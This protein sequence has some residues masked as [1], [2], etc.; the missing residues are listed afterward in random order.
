M[1]L[2]FRRML[3]VALGAALLMGL[4]AAPLSAAKPTKKIYTLDVTPPE[5]ANGSSAVTFTATFTNTSPDGISS[6]N[7]LTLTGSSDFDFTDATVEVIPDPDGSPSGFD[8][9]VETTPQ[10]KVS[11]TGLSPVVPMHTVSIVI[12]GVGVDIPPSANCGAQ[13]IP[14]GA[15]VWTGSN[16]GGNT[17]VQLPGTGHPFTRVVES[18]TSVPA[19]GSITTGDGLTATNV[20][21][22]CAQDV[23]LKRETVGSTKF[24]YLLKPDDVTATFVIQVDSWEQ[25]PAVVP[26][27]W[28]QVDTPG[29]W[30]NIQW[31]LGS[32]SPSTPTVVS[33]LAT[34][35]LPGT[36]ISCL[37]GQ[38]THIVGAGYV[39]LTEYYYLDGDWGAKRG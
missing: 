7:S 2:A 15:Q 29:T 18:S 28:T 10:F 9:V 8:V 30:H 22:T 39:Q 37:L 19:G 21:T 33:G 23:T 17:F 11:V 5:V 36:E 12:G 6:F 27:P 34:P 20:G 16:T 3:A 1:S 32:W 31:C 35:P 14:W 4:T 24:V 38:E 13:D 25:E 26:M